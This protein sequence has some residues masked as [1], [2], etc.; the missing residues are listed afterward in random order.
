[1]A[2]SLQDMKDEAMLKRMG[3]AYDRAPYE[4]MGTKPPVK[5]AAK[6]PAKPAPK[7]VEPVQSSLEEPDASVLRDLKD[8]RDLE[9]MG[10]AYDEAA[11]RSMKRGFVKGGSV[12]S[13]SKRADGC[14]QRGKTKGRFI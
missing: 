9:R 2:D 5:P 4:S 6:T 3:R 13:A 14:A 8:Q 11:P 12:G 1:M 10:R 7:K